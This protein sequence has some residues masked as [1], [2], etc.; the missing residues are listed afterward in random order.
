MALC[1]AGRNFCFIDA[2]GNVYPCLNF[3]SACDVIESTG[4]VADAKL[5]NAL[6]A[7]FYEIWNHS[8]FLHDI[9]SSSIADFNVCTS[10]EGNQGCRQCMA[11]NYE[12]HGKLFR[13]SKITCS[14]TKAAQL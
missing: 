13:P 4:R 9:R 5:G 11:L 7:P 2:M 3:K 14:L 1:L 6:Q 10:C 8:Q 12:E